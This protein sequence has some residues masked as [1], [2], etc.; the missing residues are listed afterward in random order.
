MDLLHRNRVFLSIGAMGNFLRIFLYASPTHAAASGA[1]MTAEGIGRCA[2]PD[3]MDI[4]Q[5]E[6]EEQAR[7]RSHCRNGL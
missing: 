7:V 6:L 2:C 5:L 4:I 3:V 1:S